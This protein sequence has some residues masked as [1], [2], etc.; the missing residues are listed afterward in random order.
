[1]I[2]CKLHSRGSDA[3]RGVA[4]ESL[5]VVRGLPNY[6]YYCCCYYFITKLHTPAIQFTMI[7]ALLMTYG[8]CHVCVNK[9]NKT[10]WQWAVYVCVHSWHQWV[11]SIELKLR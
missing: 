4:L 7:M 3:F 11:N 8:L 6:Y 1:M 9:I 10:R 5:A 2:A